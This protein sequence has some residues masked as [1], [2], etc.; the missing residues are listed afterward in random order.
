MGRG[1]AFT[2]A[3]DDIIRLWRESKQPMTKLAKRL[4]RSRSAIY[5][6]IDKMKEAGKEEE[7]FIRDI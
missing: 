2:Q 4:G 1:K 3:E 5:L 7:P 6:R